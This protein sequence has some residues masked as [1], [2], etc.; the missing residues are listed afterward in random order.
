MVLEEFRCD[1]E[2][3]DVITTTKVQRKEHQLFHSKDKQTCGECGKDFAS[4]RSL[5]IH[6]GRIHQ[7]GKKVSGA[8]SG[9]PPVEDP[10]EEIL[11]NS[12][13]VP[14]PSGKIFIKQLKAKKLIKDEAISKPK[15]SGPKLKQRKG[16]KV[17]LAVKEASINDEG[18]ESV[19]VEE[20]SLPSTEHGVPTDSRSGVRY[21]EAELDYSI[22]CHCVQCL[23]C[24]ELCCNNPAVRAGKCCDQR[25]LG[26]CLQP[27]QP[28][29]HAP[30]C[31]PTVS[32]CGSL[33]HV[34]GRLQHYEPL[35]LSPPLPRPLTQQEREE[36][37]CQVYSSIL[38]E[39][40]Q[41]DLTCSYFLPSSDPSQQEELEDEQEE[42][43]EDESGLLIEPYVVKDECILPSQ[44]REYT[45]RFTGDESSLL[46]DSRIVHS[47]ID[48]KLVVSYRSNTGQY[49]Q[50]KEELLSLEQ[51]K[52]L[53]EENNLTADMASNTKL[54]SESQ[55]KVSF[56]ALRNLRDHESKV[57][58]KKKDS[59][60]TASSKP[61]HQVSQEQDH[62]SQGGS[63]IQVKSKA[64][65]CSIC[66]IDFE[67]S[68]ITK[69]LLTHSKQGKVTNANGKTPNVKKIKTPKEKK[70]SSKRNEKKV[71]KE[72]PTNEKF[73]TKK[74]NG[75]HKENNSEKESPSPLDASLIESSESPDVLNSTC[76]LPSTYT[77]QQDLKRKV[78]GGAK[79]R[80]T[81]SSIERGAKK[82]SKT[83]ATEGTEAGGGKGGGKRGREK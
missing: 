67:K 83:G 6:L 41:L 17:K 34:G 69:H 59:A 55:S 70:T 57:Q 53:A 24:S 23:P 31:H 52:Y 1:H 26:H 62:L 76:P 19:K 71:L 21:A 20:E 77:S 9:F 42:E 36:A 60:E 38:A 10:E 22:P 48:Q 14:S 51:S 5:N 29:C 32:L 49:F 58:K 2:D 13:V 11:Q 4:S 61:S 35:L 73:A 65:P 47:F 8:V 7:K 68:L 56:V 16:K 43:L 72:T 79:R 3:C 33:R 54:E 82:S 78:S 30:C 74:K 27:F 37:E 50:S 25:T 18:V 45:Y 44:G 39:R 64:V 15:S 66:K 28:Q 81:L 63:K 80:R 40:E 75:I 12:L 46:A